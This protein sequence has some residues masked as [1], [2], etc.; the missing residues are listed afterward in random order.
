MGL[1][2]V[3]KQQQAV[4]AGYLPPQLYHLYSQVYTAIFDNILLL[5]ANNEV[6][7]NFKKRRRYKPKTFRPAGN[8]KRAPEFGIPLLLSAQL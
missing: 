7:L 1:K 8:V 6:N 2:I 5:A 4:M 3:H